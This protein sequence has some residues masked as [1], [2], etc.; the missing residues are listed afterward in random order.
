MTQQVNTSGKGSSKV[1]MPEQHAEARRAAQLRKSRG[2]SVASNAPKA[3]RSGAGNRKSG[4]TWSRE[5][6]ASTP[7]YVASQ[8]TYE[9]ED[10]FPFNGFNATHAGYALGHGAIDKLVPG[11][12]ARILATEALSRY[13][14]VSRKGGLKHSD[15]AIQEA[16]EFLT[17][18]GSTRFSVGVIERTTRAVKAALAQT[19]EMAQATSDAA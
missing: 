13:P 17:P 7:M 2:R 3:D 10:R 15:V 19:Y 4:F 5:E 18:E 9:T 1:I 14:L 12:A 11:S 6:Y 16:V 8:V